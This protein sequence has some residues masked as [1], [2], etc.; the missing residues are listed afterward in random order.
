[1]PSASCW[2][3]AKSRWSFT[4]TDISSRQRNRCSHL[5]RESTQSLSSPLVMFHFLPSSPFLIFLFI[6]F[7]VSTFS[8]IYPRVFFPF[9]PG[10]ASLRQPASCRTSSVSL[11]SGPSLS[12]TH[13]LSSSAP[14]MTLLHC[15]PVKRSS[16][17]GKTW[18]RSV[19]YFI[20]LF[21]GVGWCCERLGKQSVICCN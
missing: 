9:V 8:L 21:R 12:V 17:P 11:T 2:I 19:T 20:Y 16:C 10:P 15:C 6:L 14:S 3:S 4:W 13:L 5:P 7:C 1:M 18:N